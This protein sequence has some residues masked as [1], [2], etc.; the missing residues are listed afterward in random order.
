MVDL[1][2]NKINLPAFVATSHNTKVS[3]TVIENPISAA[4]INTAGMRRQF[5]RRLYSSDSVSDVAE[6]WMRCDDRDCSVQLMTV[7]AARC[8]SRLTAESPMIVTTDL[9]LSAIVSICRR[10]ARRHVER[11]TTSYRPKLYFL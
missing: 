8:S 2:S 9:S 6:Q 5:R 10:V 1:S 4:I 11:R 3:T 7:C